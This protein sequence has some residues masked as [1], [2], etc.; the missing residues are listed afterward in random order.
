MLARASTRNIL[1]GILWREMRERY[2][3]SRRI[4]SS[5]SRRLLA[6]A[7]VVDSFSYL[8]QIVGFLTAV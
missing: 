4:V 8:D 3:S 6:L 1:T 7:I 2:A 5:L